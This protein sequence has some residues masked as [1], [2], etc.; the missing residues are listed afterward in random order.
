MGRV[1]RKIKDYYERLGFY[2]SDRILG[3]IDNK[4]TFSGFRMC[5]PKISVTISAASPPTLHPLTTPMLLAPLVEGCE[6][7]I[8]HD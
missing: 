1:S 5:H 6:D 2:K 4:K 7:R 3:D 8:K